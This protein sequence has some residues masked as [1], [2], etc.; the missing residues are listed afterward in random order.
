MPAA[1]YRH[2]NAGDK[3]KQSTQAS[4]PY[5]RTRVFVNVSTTH[6]LKELCPLV[7]RPFRPEL[8]EMKTINL[9]YSLSRK[10]FMHS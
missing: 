7:A 5:T 6:K 10:K 3:I 9:K 8:Q 1:S 2:Q 4:T